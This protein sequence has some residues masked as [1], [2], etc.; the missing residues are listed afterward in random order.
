MPCKN[1][2]FVSENQ[3]PLLRKHKPSH[4]QYNQVVYNN[5]YNSYMPHKPSLDNITQDMNSY[6]KKINN[7]YNFNNYNDVMDIIQNVL[8]FQNKRFGKNFKNR[9]HNKELKINASSI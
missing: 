4:I 5:Q 7:S 6:T 1:K 8:G 2:Y 9:V 3:D